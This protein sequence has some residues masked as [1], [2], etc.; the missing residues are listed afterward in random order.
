M[1]TFDLYVTSTSSGVRENAAMV[2]Q[3]PKKH[4]TL[5]ILCLQINQEMHKAPYYTNQ[6]SKMTLFPECLC[7]RF[8]LPMS[9]M[10]IDL[11][12]IF[13]FFSI[14]SLIVPPFPPLTYL[15]SLFLLRYAKPEPNEPSRHT[16]NNCMYM[17]VW[18]SSDTGLRVITS[19]ILL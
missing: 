10:S 2:L 6:N 12:F 15:T 4:P 14:L 17:H 13:V 19:F 9:L 1:N 5:R 16:T 7:I 18:T 8:H 3:L 11:N